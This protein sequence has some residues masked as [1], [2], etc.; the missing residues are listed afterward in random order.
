MKTKIICVRLPI[1]KIGTDV[2]EANEAMESAA[3][4]SMVRM[5]VL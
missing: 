2:S 4:C 1:P 3:K 5:R